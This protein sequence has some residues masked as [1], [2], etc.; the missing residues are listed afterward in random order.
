[1]EPLGRRQFGQR[2]VWG[3][4][5]DHISAA[6]YDLPRLL[7]EHPD[8]RE[9][10]DDK[11]RRQ[12]HEREPP[13]ITGDEITGA[14][15]QGEQPDARHRENQP[16]GQPPFLVENPRDIGHQRG[17]VG[18]LSHSEQE[19]VEQVDVSSIPTGN[20]I[21]PSDVSQLAK[22]GDIDI[23]EAIAARRT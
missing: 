13:T 23:T 22:S 20:L 5:R 2:A 6:F 19:T 17:M 9:G 3:T 10:Q 8:G 15:G 16:Y 4:V 7:A 14:R 12:N 11:S 1:M 21:N 18:R